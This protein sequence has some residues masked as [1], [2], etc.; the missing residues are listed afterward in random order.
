MI[1][2]GHFFKVYLT[3]HE[4]FCLVIVY[5]TTAKLQIKIKY[6]ILFNKSIKTQLLF[7][8]KYAEI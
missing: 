4:T 8:N 5:D 2:P 3:H 1:T 6:P 7:L